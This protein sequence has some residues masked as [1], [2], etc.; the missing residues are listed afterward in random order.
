MKI[1]HISDL[2]IKVS[3][4]SHSQYKKCFEYM[5]NL[6]KEE[7]IDII[8]GAGDFLHSYNQ[9]SIEL[10]E[11]LSWFFKNISKIAPFHIITGNHD[12]V[13]SNKDKKSLIK[14]LI[15][16][17]SIPNITLYEKT[18]I[19]P[20]GNNINFIPF[21]LK[22]K[23]NWP[24]I[25]LDKTKTNIAI[26]HLCV[27]GAETSLGYTLPGEIDLDFFSE[28]DQVFLGDIHLKQNLG[29]ERK[30]KH[31]ELAPWAMYSGSPIQQNFGENP[32]K[33][34]LVWEINGK[35]DWK[36]FSFEI[37]NPNPF[38]TINYEKGVSRTIEKSKKYPKTSYFRVCLS[39]S[40][41]QLEKNQITNEL[42]ENG[43]IDV[44]WKSDFDIDISTIKTKT[45]LTSKQ[46]LQN[47]E[48][49]NKLLREYLTGTSL[50]E[51]EW[52]VLENLTKKYLFKLNKN[53][54]ENNNNWTLKKLDFSNT[55]GYGENNSI[56][57]EKLNGT[58][59]IVGKNRIGKSSILGTLMYALFDGTDRGSL[60]NVDVINRKKD[61]CSATASF[62][63]RGEDYKIER[64]TKATKNKKISST[65]TISF[66][67]IDKNG[68]VLENFDHTLKNKV[69]AKIKELIGDKDDFLKTNLARQDELTEFIKLKSTQRKIYINKFIGLTIFEEIYNLAKNDAEEIKS[70]MKTFK[71]KNWELL[72]KEAEEKININNESIAS[73]SENL[74]KQRKKENA[75]QIEMSKN[76]IGEIITETDIKKQKDL[77]NFLSN[78]LESKSATLGGIKETIEK[79]EETLKKVKNAKEQFPINKV[80]K[81]FA[82]Q[83]ETEKSL[84]KL[85]SKLRLENNVL[86][87]QEK[88]IKKLNTIPCG[89]RFPNCRFIK[90]S[91]TDKAKIENQKVKV[92]NFIE[93]IETVQ[94]NL[95]DILKNNLKEKLEKYEKLLQ[96]ENDVKIEIS[97]KK[98]KIGDLKN[99]IEKMEEKIAETT[100]ILEKMEKSFEEN[101][102]EKIKKEVEELEAIKA[103]IKVLERQKNEVIKQNGMM[104]NEIKSLKEES[105]KYSKIKKK[106][107]L[108]ELYLNAMGKTG[109]S[110]QILS[111]QIPAINKE[112]ENL[113]SGIAPFSM[114]LKADVKSNSL[115]ILIDDGETTGKI[116]TACRAEKVFIAIILRAVLVKLSSNLPVCDTL[117]LDESIDGLDEE[118]MGETEK[119]FDALKK[120]FKNVVIITHKKELKSSMDCLIQIEKKKGL[121]SVN[122]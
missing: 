47:A 83:Q 48:T 60:K 49:H 77:I 111:N 39:Q 16:E 17:L 92:G 22:D 73:L 37:P 102:N 69:E 93:T 18:Q 42:K 91:F 12:E 31:G 52:K 46:S 107:K 94:K 57:F 45:I 19:Y 100:K 121:A 15:N 32:E 8:V 55:F 68:N 21:P 88:S 62:S 30:T 58:I 79:L 112:M 118:N 29:G 115:D 64:E 3:P 85:T 98:I 28:F 14:V 6:F 87:G 9:T 84:E 90:D 11:F 75:I 34:G 54:I 63:A 25:S 36:V 38:I 2:H 96:K 114:K 65:S 13:L 89:D 27:G 20:I 78:K 56:D 59:G 44:S 119:L 105:E 82:K 101:D 51:V 43:A 95:N 67:K 23:K 97:N 5:F 72:A 7:K 10:I 120:M 106:W 86:E 117:F 81:D 53:K 41:P 113:L 40:I 74:E 109:I 76:K 24:N 80:K 108:Y 61:K 35:N 66:K 33:G 99:E 103:N 110:V 50:D 4:A 116:E 70:L 1:A 71:E 104:E 26:A 122:V